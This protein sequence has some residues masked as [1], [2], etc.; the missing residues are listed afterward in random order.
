MRNRTESIS[1]RISYEMKMELGRIANEEQRTLSQVVAMA[2]EE[3]LKAWRA[4]RP[5]K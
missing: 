3:G 4:K 1:A 5:K 2:I